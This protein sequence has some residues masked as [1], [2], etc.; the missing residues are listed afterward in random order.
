MQNKNRLPIIAF[1]LVLAIGNFSRLKGNENIRPIQY[2]SLLAIGGLITVLIGG[3]V[4]KFKDK[5]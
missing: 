1:M 4:K 2:I 3:V 5:A